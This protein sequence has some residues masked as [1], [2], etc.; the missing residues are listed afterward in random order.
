MNQGH[1][2]NASSGQDRQKNKSVQDNQRTNQSKQNQQGKREEG[3]VRIPNSG[4]FAAMNRRT[5]R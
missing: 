1:T 3:G 4:I 2:K 5:S